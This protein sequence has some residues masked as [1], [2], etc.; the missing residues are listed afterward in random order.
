MGS[1]M[2]LV[3]QLPQLAVCVVALAVAL[4]RWNRHPQASML[5]TIGATLELGAS[6]G[7]TVMMTV[8]RDQMGSLSLVFG[9]MHLVGVTGF[10]LIVAAVFSERGQPTS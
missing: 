10:A 7:S 8:L 6:I 1:M 9:V 5:V 4:G 2:L 3:G